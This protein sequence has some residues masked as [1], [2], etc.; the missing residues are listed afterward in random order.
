M[1][2]VATFN[3]NGINGRLPMLLR[4]LAEAKPDIVCLQASSVST[5]LPARPS[6]AN[7]VLLDPAVARPPA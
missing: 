1:M 5:V 6:P 7:H 2:K 3:V 4:W